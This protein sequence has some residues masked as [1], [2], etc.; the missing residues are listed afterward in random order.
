MVHRKQISNLRAIQTLLKTKLFSNGTNRLLKRNANATDANENFKLNVECA[1]L[2]VCTHGV[3]LTHA[4]A[5]F[6]SVQRDNW[7]NSYK[8]F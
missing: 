6:W 4:R 5:I 7:W 1:C 3:S 8:S 2:V